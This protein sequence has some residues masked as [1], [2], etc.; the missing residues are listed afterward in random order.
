MSNE[1]SLILYYSVFGFSVLASALYQ[2]RA[3]NNVSILKKIIYFLLIVSP[4]I[5]MQSYRYNVGTDYHAYNV[6]FSEIIKGPGN[7]YWNNYLKEPLYLLENIISYKL[8]GD[9][10]GLFLINAVMESVFIFFTFDYFKEKISMPLCYML[11][12]FMV[13]PSFFNAERQAVAVVIVW[14]SLRFLIE[15]KLIK[16]LICVIIAACFH[17]TAVI[18]L[19]LYLIHYI[20]KILSNKYFLIIGGTALAFVLFRLKEF[21]NFIMRV[22]PKLNLYQRY[23]LDSYQSTSAAFLIPVLMLLPCI[24]FVKILKK[25]EKYNVIY[26]YLYIIDVCVLISS[27]IV[28]YGTRFMMYFNISVIILIS[29]TFQSLRKQFNRLFVFV[30]YCV[31]VLIYFYLLYYVTGCDQIFPYQTLKM[32]G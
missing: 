20:K 10:I 17:N 3:Q 2:K 13:Y 29:M 5:A 26:L 16:Y 7:F 19:F 15:K 27:N 32:R 31:A 24:F 30:A 12:Y 6:L 25:N 8:F 11:C 22:V 28:A 18:C 14:F 4:V 1:D 23:L 21:V 9:C